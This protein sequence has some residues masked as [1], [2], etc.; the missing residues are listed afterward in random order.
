MHIKPVRERARAQ[1]ASVLVREPEMGR[2]SDQE[3]APLG[4]CATG[5][6]ASICVD[7]AVRSLGI[8]AV[9]D[10]QELNDLAR[11]AQFSH[12]ANRATLLAQDE[13]ADHIFNVTGG[14]V[15]LY[16]L[17]SDGRRQ[18]VGF[19]MPGDFLGLAMTRANAFSADAVGAVTACRFSREA[20]GALLEAK[21]RLLLR[22]HELATHELT[23]AQDQM[24]LLG[25][26][27]AEE[28]VAAFLLSMRERWAR[29]THAHLHVP[30]PMSRQ[31]IGDFLGLTVETVSRMMTKL[32]REKLIVVVPD[33]V[34]I[35]DEERLEALRAS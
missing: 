1:A 17:L 26:R 8:C 5:G 6:C 31:D 14:V 10:P 20:F 34:R 18:I 30:L 9:L 28:K 21:P 25:R 35:L 7:C 32:A 23:L 3:A 16:R 4:G 2:L 24:V 15:R 12:F 22:L 29:V 11:L 33:G 19:A 13:P 27:T